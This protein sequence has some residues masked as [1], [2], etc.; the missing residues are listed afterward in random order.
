MSSAKIS[1][2]YGMYSTLY[3]NPVPQATVKTDLTPQSK[4]K[5]MSCAAS[6]LP[7]KSPPSFSSGY[8]IQLIGSKKTLYSGVF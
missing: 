2:W 4:S 6:M 8:K 1:S 5:F 3:F 7:K